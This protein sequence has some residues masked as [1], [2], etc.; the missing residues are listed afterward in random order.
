MRLEVS[1]QLVSSDEFF[2]ILPLDSRCV[3]FSVSSHCILKY[4]KSI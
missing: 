1:A 2:V 3:W 4:V